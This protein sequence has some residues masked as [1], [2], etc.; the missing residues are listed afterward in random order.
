M[1]LRMKIVDS[2]PMTQPRA[3]NA[4]LTLPTRDCVWRMV[5]GVREGDITEHFEH[6]KGDTSVLVHEVMSEQR[7]DEFGGSRIGLLSIVRSVRR[8]KCK[9]SEGTVPLKKFL[10]RDREI[11]APNWP[12]SLGMG[13]RRRFVERSR[14]VTGELI[15]MVGNGP[16]RRFWKRSMVF[17]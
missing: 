9:S 3:I 2:S 13:P 8:V 14:R 7:E 15:G 11:A 10:E 4:A 17:A 6:S 12:T 5:E 16:L 1:H